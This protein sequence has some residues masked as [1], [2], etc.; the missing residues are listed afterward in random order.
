MKG[1]KFWNN[2]IGWLSFTIAVIVYLSTIEPSMSLWDCGEFIASSY[3]LEVGHPPGAPL[4]LM[5]AKIFSLLTHDTAKIALF[6]NAFSA[7]ASAFTILFLFWTITILGSKLTDIKNASGLKIILILG[8]GFVGAMA[9]MFSDSFWFSAVESEVYSTS[10]LFTALV[11]W[12]ILKW[13]NQAETRYANRWIILIA[14]LVGLSIG[15][16]LLNLLAIPS[17]VLVYYFKKYPFSV[18]GFV[19]AIVLSFVLLIIVQYG[20]IA[21]LIVLASKFELFFVNKLHFPFNSGA[22]IYGILIVLILVAGII[23]TRKYQKVHLNTIFMGFSMLLLGYSSYALIIIRANAD[24]PLNENNPKDLFSLLYYLNREQYGDRPLFYGQYYNAPVLE[25]KDGAPNYV[26]GKEKYEIAGNKI[27]YVYDSRFMTFFPRMYSSDATHVKIYKDWANIKGVPLTVEKND[28]QAIEHKPTFNE[29]LKFFFKYQLGYMYFRYFMWNFSGKQ[30]DYHGDGGIF[31][32]NWLTGISPLDSY[33]FGPQDKL[34]DYLKNNKGRNRYF[35]FPLLL[36]LLGLIYQIKKSKKGFIIVFTLFFMTGIAI[37]L[38][39]NQTPL[40]PRERDYAYVGSFYAF[41]I[42]IGIGTMGFVALLKKLFTQR[43]A[44]FTGISL[45]ILAVPA[46]MG[47]ENYDD[48]D[49]SGRYLAR[50]MAYNYLNSCAP[51]AILFTNG[52]NDTFPLWYLQ[53]VE[54]IRRDVRV[55]N[56]ILLGTDWYINQTAKQY[57]NSQPVPMSLKGDKIEKGKRDVVYLTENTKEYLDVKTAIEFVAN[58]NDSNRILSVNGN[59]LYYF[60]EKNF[61]LPVDS[62][63]VLKNGTSGSL[64]DSEF[65]PMMTFRLSKGYIYKNELMFLDIL[66]Q[67][68]W[69]RP[70]YFTSPTYSGTMGLQR[71]IRLEGFAYRLTPIALTITD[72]LEPG[73]VDSKRLY[74]NLMNTFS[75]RGTNDKS[76]YIDDHYRRTYA[77][78]RLRVNFAR[79]IKQLVIEHKT[80]SAK[81][82]VT[83]YTKLFPACNFPYNVYSFKLVESFYMAG[84]IK[85]ADNILLEYGKQSIETMHFIH[86]LRPTLQLLTGVDKAIASQT[87]ERIRNIALANNRENIIN[88]LI[89][90]DKNL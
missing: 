22:I 80:D 26:K 59:P 20:I 86:D 56:L 85:E 88:D 76:I 30:N 33:I 7:I 9:Y 83:Q 14:Y 43:V 41:A 45:T 42:W 48:H 5:L 51:N 75:W 90:F 69:K 72:N 21:G 36:G 73:V 10:S 81:N 66:S 3:K 84:A 39:L 63:N 31:E 60:R 25:I 16:H 89:E 78:M 46:I 11:F 50:D 62:Q 6:M 2:C 68:N 13:E 64:K 24:T 17:I 12:A 38:Y 53:E 37:V 4:F 65:Q 55:I 54:G 47:F 87:L 49:R 77:Y 35:M 61:V 19:L 58:D 1:F 32:G 29:N 8:S 18:K 67:N 23:L 82:V 71:Y 57:Y 52:D 79:L 15:V 27:E 44:T 34:P 40:Q 74:D 28:K 70:I